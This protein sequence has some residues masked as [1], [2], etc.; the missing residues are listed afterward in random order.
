MRTRVVGDMGRTLPL[1]VSEK[2]RAAMQEVLATFAAEILLQARVALASTR[3]AE[4]DVVPQLPALRE[5]ADRL[6]RSH[7]RETSTK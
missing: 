4:N 5:V 2:Q 7:G 6:D 1:E 3:T